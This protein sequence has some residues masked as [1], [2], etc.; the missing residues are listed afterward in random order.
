MDPEPPHEGA[1]GASPP[2]GADGGSRGNDGRESPDPGAPG[3][4]ASGCS[5]GPESDIAR[6]MAAWS[7]A[8]HR[9]TVRMIR[10]AAGTRAVQVRLQ[11][12]ILQMEVEG[13]PDGRRPHGADSLLDWHLARLEA[14]A[15]RTGGSAG[16]EL[17]ARECEALRDEATQVYHR[18]VALFALEE[19]ELVVRD[20][21]RNLRLFDLC[22]LH[23]AEPADR[24]ALERYRPFVVMMRTR[25]LAAIALAGG[26]SRAAL[27][28]VDAA[29]AALRAHYASH[30]PADGFE[31]SGEATLL[32]GMRDALVPRLP[33]SQRAELEERLRRAVAAENFE[34]AALLRDEIRSLEG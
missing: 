12:G 25:A 18:Y 26:D 22:R 10:T 34:L 11:L 4:G 27:H 1:G 33:A 32:R 9:P 29:L 8:T 2:P 31:R 15:E 3:G 16:F 6:I 24:A 20:T 17:G 5:A 23:A 14:H 30:G 7:F 28:A 21:G 19:F 13:R